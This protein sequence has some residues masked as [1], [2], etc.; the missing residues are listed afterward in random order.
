MHQ[1]DENLSRKGEATL[2]LSVMSAFA[3][4]LAGIQ[5]VPGAGVGAA[6][7]SDQ[8]MTGVSLLVR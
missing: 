3:D 5:P 1:E 4:R 7:I 8:M 6:R 2:S